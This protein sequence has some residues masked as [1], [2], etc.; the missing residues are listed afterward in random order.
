MS[1]NTSNAL[2]M[3]PGFCPNRPYF[4]HICGRDID[5]HAVALGMTVAQARQSN[6]QSSSSYVQQ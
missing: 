3:H 2:N 1:Q 4:C 6:E 5:R